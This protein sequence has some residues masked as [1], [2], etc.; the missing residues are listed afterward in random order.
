[1]AGSFT[2]EQPFIQPVVYI[3]SLSP[4]PSV[5]GQFESRCCTGKPILFKDL[6]D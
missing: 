4:S 1:M 2:E 6:K 3:I 5:T